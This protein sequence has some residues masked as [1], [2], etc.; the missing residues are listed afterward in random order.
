MEVETKPRCEQCMKP[1]VLNE[2]RTEITFLL[3]ESKIE[4]NLLSNVSLLT[5]SLNKT[6]LKSSK[7]KKT[8]LKCKN[9]HFNQ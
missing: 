3:S 5:K 7:T 8:K 6:G 1:K 9:V 4:Q 2:I